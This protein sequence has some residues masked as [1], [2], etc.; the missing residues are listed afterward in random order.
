MTF[1]ISA[2]QMCVLHFG[3]FYENRNNSGLIPGQNDDPVTR[4]P[5]RERWP[6]W[7]VDPV[8][9]WPSSMSGPQQEGGDTAAVTPVPRQHEP[10]QA[11][12]DQPKHDDCAE[13]HH[14]QHEREHAA[15]GLDNRRALREISASRLWAVDERFGHRVKAESLSVTVS[16]M[17]NI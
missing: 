3:H 16:S 6:K 2:F 14:V 9:Q 5:G 1:V 11:V 7:P 10:R 8:T 12:A 13:H 15:V 4:W 17:S